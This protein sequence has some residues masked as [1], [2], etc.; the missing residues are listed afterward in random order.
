[1]QFYSQVGQDRFLFENFFYGHRGGTFVD[2][3]AYDGEKFSNTL[4]FERHLG[5]A[6][7][8]IEP[9]P[10]AFAKLT[11]KRKVICKQVCV[12]DF[13][14]EP[15]ADR[16]RRG[17]RSTPLVRRRTTVAERGDVS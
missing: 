5:W 12:S 6:R 3:G 2:V 7:L 8:C 14:G 16:W 9:L 11:E 15:A 1:M 10:S 13:E 17:R 4:F